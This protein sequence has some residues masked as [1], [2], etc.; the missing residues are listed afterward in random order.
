MLDF[1][2]NPKASRGKAK[3][4]AKKLEKILIA[5]NVGYTFH[6]TSSAEDTTALAAKLSQTATDI[7]VVGGDG[8]VNR[9][10]NGVDTEKVNLGII[11]AGSGNDFFQ[12]PDRLF[13]ADMVDRFSPVRQYGLFPFGLSG[14]HTLSANAVNGF[15]QF[16]PAPEY[17]IEGT[18]RPAGQITA[19]QDNPP[20]REKCSQD[21]R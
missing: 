9:A 10:F 14:K 3:K 6:Y 15:Q 2:I 11:A 12:P 4:I 1:I 20:K 18:V 7:I 16:R 8:T 19:P 21:S 13:T 5:K 17:G